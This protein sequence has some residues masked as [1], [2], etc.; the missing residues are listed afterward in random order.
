MA[1]IRTIKP[2]FFTSEDIVSLSP[3]ARLLYIG[4][5][6]EADK[7]G[8]LVWKPFTF[9]LR[10]LPGDACDIKALCQEIVDQGLVVLYGD[11]YAVVPA[12]S[13]HQHVNPRESD[14]VIP[15]PDGA[16]PVTKTKS[17]VVDACAR[18]PDASPRV[19]HAQGGRE[20]K[21]KEREGSVGESASEHAPPEPSPHPADAGPPPTDPSDFRPEYREVITTQ[22]PDLTAT[23]MQVWLLFCE[24]YPL[25][26]RGIAR[27]TKWV[28]NEK[29]AGPGVPAG[30]GLGVAAGAAVT[31]PSTPGVDKT[32][33]RI[34]AED[35]HLK[36]MPPELR[37]Q[38][39]SRKKFNEPAAMD[40][41]K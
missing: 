34:L 25:Q 28:Q 13:K 24:Q 8:R 3:L 19:P 26:K 27:W 29:A 5:W 16:A 33:A 37:E 36:P 39:R 9:K 4:I 1:R 18:V 41:E 30:G 14:S 17:R 31:V 12:F 22:R 38:W 6:C 15:A 35:Q 10:Y 20:G 32:L 7:E 21:G 11:G 23:A 2:D 40:A